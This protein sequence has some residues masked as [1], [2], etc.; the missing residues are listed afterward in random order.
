MST[1]PL[2]LTDQLRRPLQDL[3]ISVTDRCNFR[4]TYCMP[5]EIFGERYRFLPRP[6]VLTFEEIARLAAIAVSLGVRKIRLTGGEP[7]LRVQLPRL[8]AQLRA[9]SPE[10]DLAMTTNGVLL[11]RHARDLRAAGL[12]RLTVSL[13]SLDEAVFRRMNGGKAAVQDVLDGI[14]AAEAAG[15]RQMKINAVVQR[16]VNEDSIVPLAA[17]FRG[18]GHAVRYIEYMD[19]GT[20]NDWSME[21]VVPAAEI[22]GRIDA[23]FPLEPVTRQPASETARRWRYRDGAG[24]IGVIASV[25]QPFCGA[26]S[27]LRLSADG[28]LFTCLFASAGTDVKGR[29]RAGASDAELAEILAGTWRAR[30]DRYSE[31]RTE[32]TA[33]QRN[34]VEM[35]AIGG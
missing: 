22:I 16:G 17:H 27:R 7:L 11:P 26:C 15:F 5:E 24:E 35:Y 33:R 12:D 34:R 6:E 28:R 13:D 4:C 9:I 31:V 19:V 18:T 32:E 25:T 21:H 23:V 8:V 30:T 2:P 10:L 14:A 3:R 20:R 29:L 1:T